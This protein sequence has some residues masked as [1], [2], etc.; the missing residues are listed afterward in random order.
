MDERSTILFV[1]VYQT[2]IFGM[3]LK[4]LIQ[5]FTRNL[6][7]INIQLLFQIVQVLFFRAR[8]YFR[9]LAPRLKVD[10]SDR[11]RAK[12]NNKENGLIFMAYLM[13]DMWILLT[14]RYICQ[15]L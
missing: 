15:D 3:C 1:N 14:N 8:I 6:V 12:C 10:E 11:E 5:L 13:C 2:Y 4:S 7:V 9:H